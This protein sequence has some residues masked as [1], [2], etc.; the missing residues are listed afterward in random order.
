M[1]IDAAQSTAECLIYLCRCA[2]NR[3]VP[4]AAALRSVDLESLYFLASRH[5][6]A[7][8]TGLALRAAGISTEK[9]DAAIAATC[10]KT[11]IL[12]AEREQV[13]QMLN[14]AGIWFVTLKGS[15]IK[16]WYPEFGM[17][18]SADCDILFDRSCREQ[19]RDIMTR[20]GYTVDS[21]GGGHHDVYLKPPVT[22]MQ[23]HVELFGKGFA[24]NLNN[25][26][27][28]I[29]RKLV[30]KSGTE[31]AFLPSDLYIY[32][33]AHE[34][35]HFQKAGTGLRSLLD[36]YV[37]LQKLRDTLNW[38]YLEDA[39]TEL[40]IRDFEIQNR[41]LALHL[42]ETGELNGRNLD[43]LERYI[44]SGVHGNL[45]FQVQ[46]AV[47]KFGGG[48]KGK[49]QYFFRRA[50][51]P[52]SLVKKKFP[53]FYR[54]KILLPFLPVYRAFQGLRNGKLNREL[55]ILTKTE[56]TISDSGGKK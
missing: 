17:R 49:A 41:E 6:L 36:T 45:T 43:L 9:F 31:L 16:D 25:Y 14:E 18:E 2:V 29:H 56:S 40:G 54:W 52:M 21:Y 7:S 48:F 3:K 4:D 10:R 42:F 37:V 8:I 20:L 11:I 32:L 26:F 39:F 5:M 35:H 1:Q 28:G 47:I 55:L 53:L 34:W 12:D 46:N 19:V 23:M 13:S 44:A 27:E 30:V 15:L 22:N 50:F 38:D 51:L 24:D 33:I